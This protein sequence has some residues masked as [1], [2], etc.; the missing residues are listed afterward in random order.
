MLEPY[1]YATALVKE[2]LNTI[3]A[4]AA[5][6]DVNRLFQAGQP[7]PSLMEEPPKNSEFTWGKRLSLLV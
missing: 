2:S 5:A 1:S 4:V 7:I 6:T 3:N